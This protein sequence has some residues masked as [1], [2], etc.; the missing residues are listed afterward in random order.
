MLLLKNKE[1]LNNISISN[2]QSIIKEKNRI[3]LYFNGFSID[4]KDFK[5]EIEQYYYFLK[6]L[7]ENYEII[8]EEDFRIEILKFFNKSIKEINNES[9]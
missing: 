6:S 8:E 1:T 5:V 3:T 2:L 9:L 4:V 7:E